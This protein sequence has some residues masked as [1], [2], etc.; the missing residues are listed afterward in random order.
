MKQDEG[1]DQNP[2]RS[3]AQPSSLGDEAAPMGPKTL[4]LATRTNQIVCGALIQGIIMIVGV[5]WFIGDDADMH[6]SA[7]VYLLIGGLVFVGTTVGSFVAPHLIQGDY[8]LEPSDELAD[9]IANV[10]WNETL[11]PHVSS[12]MAAYATQSLVV[13][14]FLEGGAVVNSVFWLLNR[15]TFHLLLIVLAIVL[16]V[17]RFPTLGRLREFLVAQVRGEF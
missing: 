15:N 5:F 13:A 14:A 11:P 8:A 9:A 4:R 2:Y 12:L 10:D 17:I 3:P 16:M 1:Q 6:E 7:S